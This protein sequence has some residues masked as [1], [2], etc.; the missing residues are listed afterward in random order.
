M[1]NQQ[2]IGYA[3]FF[4]NAV[5]TKNTGIDIVV[6]YNTRW[7]NKHFSASLAGNIQN[8]KI[9]Q[10]N[11]PSTF[12]DHGLDSA[13]FF[14]DREQYFLKSSAPKAKF[15]LNLE[16]GVGKIAIG[17]H[18]TYFGEVKELGFGTTNPPS[19]VDPYFPYVTTDVGS[20]AVP[21]IF[22]FKP[23]LVTDLYISLKLCK[24]ASLVCGV[25]N[26]FNVHPNTAVVPGAIG[27][28]WGDSE[29]GGAFDAVQMGSNGL[30]MFGKL[31]FHF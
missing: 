1:L 27:D 6:D 18:L 4:T 14:S 3:Q 19:G 5:N 25:D 28:S 31:S 20:Q 2:S 29:S 12:N 15:S 22:T 11:V 13:S 26:I 23:K 21:E 9:T 24:A 16:Y 30:R 8:L 17:T 7:K 10:I